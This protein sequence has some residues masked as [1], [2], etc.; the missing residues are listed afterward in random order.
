MTVDPNTKK[1]SMVRGD[2]ETITI[3]LK[4]YLFKTGDIVKF[5]VRK[6]VKN[7]E[8]TIHKVVTEF[9][10]SGKA[11]IEIE[12]EDTNN[13][14]FGAYTYDVEWTNEAGRVKTI[15]KPSIFMIEEEVTYGI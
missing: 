8:I 1:L 15:I 13:L 4:S 11:V 2:S 5:T 9:T 10:E 14:G 6:T 3:S 12:P 7:P